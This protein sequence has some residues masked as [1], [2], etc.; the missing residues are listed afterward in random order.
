MPKYFVISTTIDSGKYSRSNLK[1]EIYQSEYEKTPGEMTPNK[2]MGK[3]IGEYERNYSSLFNTFV[4]F[5]Q[6]DKWYALYSKEYDETRVMELP[7]CRDLGGEG[8]EFC[9]VEY[10]VPTLADMQMGRKHKD[11]EWNKQFKAV[12]GKFG[13]VSGCVWGDDNY[14]KIAYMNL[15]K[16]NEGKIKIDF[17]FGYI[18]QP[19]K[20]S[21]KECIDLSN[22]SPGPKF[23]ANS[24]DIVHSNMFYLDEE[25]LV[26]EP[27]RIGGKSEAEVNELPLY[28]G[29]NLNDFSKEELIKLIQKQEIQLDT[30][31]E[32]L[33]HFWNFKRKVRDEFGEYKMETLLTDSNP[34]KN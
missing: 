20:Y 18:Q 14:W 8:S 2:Q 19:P 29:N 11:E 25:Y 6:G 27:M 17:R 32:E 10:Y 9:P 24:I 28:E 23:N 26:G 3:K 4:P 7:S 5:K 1:V 22:Y 30:R 12:E 16:A 15:E 33:T 31:T 34:T 21:L 13:F